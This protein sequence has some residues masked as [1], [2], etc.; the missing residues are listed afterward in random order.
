MRAMLAGFALVLLAACGGDNA[1]TKAGAADAA[2]AA[3][4][5]AATAPAVASADPAR[6]GKL[7]AC[8]KDV[9]NEL[10]QG[11][12]LNAFCGCAVDG[13][14]A[15]KDERGAMEACADKMGIKPKG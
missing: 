10:P 13:M 5:A 7:E 11:A 12:D 3:S 2:D 15:G 8:R 9:A 14:A 1:A 4:N 6:E